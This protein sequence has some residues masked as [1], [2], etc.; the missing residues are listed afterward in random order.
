MRRNVN[1]HLRTFSGKPEWMPLLRAELSRL[2]TA[3]TAA[4]RIQSRE[5]Y[6]RGDYSE[7]RVRNRVFAYC[8]RR[9]LQRTIGYSRRS[10]SRGCSGSSGPK[11]GREAGAVR[12]L[13][14]SANGE[15]VLRKVHLFLLG[16]SV[17]LAAL[18]CLVEVTAAL[19][20]F[21][22]APPPDTPGMRPS[23]SAA[24]FPID[25]FPGGRRSPP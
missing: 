23:S 22:V 20:F 15:T 25:E 5:R 24:A 7:K 13:V 18:F 8:S 2:S 17:S 1:G 12:S 10:R 6:K 14:F 16:L 3:Q 9:H 11:G 21:L 19:Y 4:P